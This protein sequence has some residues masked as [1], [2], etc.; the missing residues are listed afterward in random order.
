MTTMLKTPERVAKPVVFLLLAAPLIGMVAAGF[1]GELGANP[2][3]KLTHETGEWALRLLIATLA[4]TPLR[5]L[6]RINWL[7]RLRRMLGLY[8]F[9]YVSLHFLTYLWLDQFFDFE[10]IVEDIFKR[11]YITLGFTGVLVLIPLAITSTNAMVK[12]LGG[13]RWQALHRLAYVAAVL[14]CLH[15][16]WLVKADYTEPALYSAVLAVLLLARV[17]WRR[18]KSSRRVYSPG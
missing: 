10:A 1:M 5:K 14:G 16:L 4:I 3:E 12:T 8:A 6:T 2:V 7:A 18:K 13:K 9:F 11:P 15:Y 17:P